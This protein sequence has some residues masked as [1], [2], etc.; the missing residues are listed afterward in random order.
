MSESYKWWR[1]SA[2]GRLNGDEMVQIWR[3]GGSEKFVS[4]WDELV[5]IAFF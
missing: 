1:A 3:F 4:K 5:L 2:A